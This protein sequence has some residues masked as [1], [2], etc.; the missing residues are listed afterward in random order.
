[1]RNSHLHKECNVFDQVR[2]LLMFQLGICYIARLHHDQSMN[3]VDNHSMEQIQEY[4]IHQLGIELDLDDHEVVCVHLLVVYARLLVVCARLLVVY[5]RLL[6]VYARLLVV[7]A[8]LLVVLD[9]HHVH[10]HYDH[11]LEDDRHRCC[12]HLVEVDCHHFHYH[13]YRLKVEDCRDFRYRHLVED[14]YHHFRYRQL[15]VQLELEVTNHHFLYRH[16]RYHFLYRHY[17]RRYYCHLRYHGHLGQ[18]QKKCLAL[19]IREHR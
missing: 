12:R 9:Y 4:R 1:M 16:Y 6:V 7:C 18:R 2:P 11:R 8:R 17:H 5:A 10:C 3:L 15:V 13:D 14:D 19:P